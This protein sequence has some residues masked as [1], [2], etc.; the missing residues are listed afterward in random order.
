MSLHEEI[1][2]WLE[3]SGRVLDENARAVRLSAAEARLGRAFGVSD[4]VAAARAATDAGI[5]DEVS[6]EAMER[7][8]ASM[9]EEFAAAAPVQTRA[10]FTFDE[11]VRAQRRH[12]RQERARRKSMFEQLCEQWRLERLSTVMRRAGEPYDPTRGEA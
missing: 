8:M 6:P 4:R 10:A 9:A 1:D 2:D 12:Q 5:V 7:V 11:V 3:R